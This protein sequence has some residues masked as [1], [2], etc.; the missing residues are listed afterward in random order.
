MIPKNSLRFKEIRFNS[1]PVKVI[2]IGRHIYFEDLSLGIAL[3]AF[4]NKKQAA[5]KLMY[6]EYRNSAIG[7]IWGK[8]HK[9]PVHDDT[10]PKYCYSIK[11]VLKIAKRSK[12]AKLST[13]KKWLKHVHR[14][15]MVNVT[16]RKSVTRGKYREPL[17]KTKLHQWHK[18]HPHTVS[19]LWIAK[20]TNVPH[21][22]VLRKISNML[23]DFPTYEIDGTKLCSRDYFAYRPYRNKQNHIQP[24]YECTEMGCEVYAQKLTGHRGNQFSFL[25]THKFHQYRC[26]AKHPTQRIKLQ[27]AMKRPK[28]VLAGMLLNYKHLYKKDHQ[29]A[30]YA[31]RALYNR[32]LMPITTIA[33]DMGK[34]ARQ[35]NIYLEQC[36]VQHR[37]GKVWYLTQQYA[38]KGLAS[39]RYDEQNHRCLEWTQRGR[40]F[41]LHL[42]IKS[43]Y[44][45][46]NQQSKIVFKFKQSQELLNKK[47]RE[48]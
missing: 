17:S 36:H 21:K 4:G 27:Q 16:C 31:R 38:D 6:H 40:M 23:E 41:I 20:V 2:R 7:L 13:V 44:V 12:H 8:Y 39:Y 29:D 34:S 28:L 42:S 26:E 22:T 15:M 3:D 24:S 32:N 5:I 37:I 19:S 43:G 11:Q 18:K 14:S 1:R 33:H 30:E 45:Q 47:W 35:L 10:T 46:K 48:A 25:Y 9:S